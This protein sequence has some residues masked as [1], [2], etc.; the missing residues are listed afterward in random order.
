VPFERREHHLEDPLVNLGPKT[1]LVCCVKV[2]FDYACP[3]LK[4]DSKVWARP[5]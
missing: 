5:H 2:G 3:E 1:R 4:V